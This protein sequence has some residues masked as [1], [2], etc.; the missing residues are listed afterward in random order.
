MAEGRAAHIPD[1][2]LASAAL[3][4]LIERFTYFVTSRDL[5]L[6]D[7]VVLTTMATVIHRG[8]FA[9]GARRR[10]APTR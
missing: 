8:F 7:E 5:G 3:L 9:D 10:P 6:D 4:A 1:P 2:D